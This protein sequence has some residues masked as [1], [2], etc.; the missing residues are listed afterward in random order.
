M[1]ILIGIGAVAYISIGI[2]VGGYL[3]ERYDPKSETPIPAAGGAFWPAAIV[4]AL[5]IALGNCF[6]PACLAIFGFGRRLEHRRRAKLESKTRAKL[7]EAKLV[8]R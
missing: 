1:N 7:P 2:A 8:D 4:I 5:L 6:A 3:H